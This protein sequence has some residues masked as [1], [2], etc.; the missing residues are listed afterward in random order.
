MGYGFGIKYNLGEIKIKKEMKLKNDGVNVLKIRS[1]DEKIFGLG[2]WDHRTRIY[3]WK[4]FKPLC[5][6]KGHKGG[7]TDIDFHPNKNLL[8]T[9]S[10][11]AQIAMYELYLNIKTQTK[12]ISFK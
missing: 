1:Y 4:T 8:A 7:I 3:E 9:S 10:K 6:L 5:I 12:I 11:D 2:G